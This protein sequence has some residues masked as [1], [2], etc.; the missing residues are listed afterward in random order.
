M[1]A[2]RSGNSH[3]LNPSPRDLCIMVAVSE[4]S[5]LTWWCCVFS[6]GIVLTVQAISEDDHRF[7]MQ[8]MGGK[9][10]V[11][12]SHCETQPARLV[13]WYLTLCERAGWTWNSCF[14]PSVIQMCSKYN[15]WF[16]MRS[17]K[18]IIDF[19]SYLFQVHHLGKTYSKERG[20]KL[21]FLKIK[22]KRMSSSVQKFAFS[23]MQK[24]NQINYEMR[25]FSA[26]I[27]NQDVKR[28]NSL[29]EHLGFF[30]NLFIF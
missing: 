27:Q 4:V 11:S 28:I 19:V 29:K 14:S 10:P 9:E 21:N 22:E 3:L 13:V 15:L 30:F 23:F 18:D 7:W 24:R 8:A 26:T 25:F 16:W 12:E 6:P 1:D 2:T 5:Y 20:S 17:K